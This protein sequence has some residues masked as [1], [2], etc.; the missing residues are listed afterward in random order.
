[1]PHTSANG[2]NGGR[3]RAFQR[4]T[5]DATPR[6]GANL[7]TPANLAAKFHETSEL[8]MSNK[9]RRNYRQRLA[10]IIRFW[11]KEDVEYYTVGVKEV[12]ANDLHDRTKYFF[13][14]HFDED[15]NPWPP[16]DP[17]PL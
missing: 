3:I 12:S 7:P 10:R 9:C 15:L 6:V 5:N 11:K 14:G 4:D 13:D 1:M 8:A 17:D 16:K 2:R